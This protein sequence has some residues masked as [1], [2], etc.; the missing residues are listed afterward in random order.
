MA[1]AARLASLD[2]ELLDQSA[3]H[4]KVQKRGQDE[5]DERWQ[6]KQKKAV[7]LKSFVSLH[8]TAVF[9]EKKK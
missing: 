5:E 1:E 6:A 8:S 3:Q 7:V 9:K 4:C 2:A